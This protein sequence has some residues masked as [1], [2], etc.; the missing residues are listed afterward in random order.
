MRHRSTRKNYDTFIYIRCNLA[1][2]TGLSWLINNKYF[3][4]VDGW[5]SG[6][7]ETEVAWRRRLGG[8]RSILSEY[9]GLTLHTRIVAARKGMTIQARERERTVNPK[10]FRSRVS[11]GISENAAEFEYK[12]ERSPEAYPPPSLPPHPFSLIYMHIN[13]IPCL[14][15]GVVRVTHAHKC[16]S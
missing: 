1:V 14:V 5:K 10:A 2:E 4:R 6:E 15:A 9:D 16:Q 13:T 11:A 12:R 8:I 3:E 7:R